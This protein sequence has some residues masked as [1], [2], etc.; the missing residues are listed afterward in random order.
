M[1][2]SSGEVYL[3]KYRP[4]RG[5]PAAPASTAVAHTALHCL[6]CSKGNLLATAAAADAAAA[7]PMF[8]E[9]LSNRQ[10]VFD[11]SARYA[12]AASPGKGAACTDSSMSESRGLSL[13]M[14]VYSVADRRLVSKQEF[15]D[16]H[17]LISLQDNVYVPMQSSLPLQTPRHWKHK[18]HIR[19]YRL[20][21]AVC[22]MSCSTG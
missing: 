4:R 7:W 17:R 22:L 2:D 1:D 12:P 5:N 20:L 9:A 18:V 16:S 15:V 11:D 3:L 14:A 13:H 10:L 6:T 19:D 8:A 21:K